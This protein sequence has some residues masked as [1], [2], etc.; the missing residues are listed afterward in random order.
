MKGSFDNDAEFSTFFSGARWRA[1]SAAL[2]RKWT[3]TGSD[4][5]LNAFLTIHLPL[6]PWAAKRFAPHRLDHEDA[7]QI[8]FFALRK[9]AQKFNPDHGAQFS[10]YASR[11]LMQ[12]IGRASPA[13]TDIVKC[14]S[15]RFAIYRQCERRADRLAAQSGEWRASRFLEVLTYR[16]TTQSASF[17]RAIRHIDTLDDPKH[18]YRRMLE[19]RPDPDPTPIEKMI[20]DERI[21]RIPLVLATLPARDAAILRKRFGLDGSGQESTLAEIGN[22]HGL[23]K[24]RVRQVLMRTLKD[25]RSCFDEP[26]EPEATYRHPLARSHCLPDKANHRR[27]AVTSPQTAATFQTESTPRQPNLPAFVQRPTRALAARL[28]APAVINANAETKQTAASTGVSL[29]S[30]GGRMR[31]DPVLEQIESS[32]PQPSPDI[33]HVKRAVAEATPYGGALVSEII[34]TLRLSGTRIRTTLHHLAR[35]GEVER[36]PDLRWKLAGAAHR[37]K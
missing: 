5:D 28:N 36:G 24:E 18:P 33:Q 1:L 16:R 34:M 31:S 35:S 19:Q 13:M 17:F 2:H 20:H 15:G 9:A 8:G 23:T 7:A 25:L 3:E 37:S 4:N 32:S 12:W 14:R 26:T 10:T 27:H 21:A 30:E 11:A 6:L 29:Q 22:A